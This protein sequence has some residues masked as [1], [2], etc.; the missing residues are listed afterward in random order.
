MICRGTRWWAWKAPKHYHYRLGS[1]STPMPIYHAD[2]VLFNDLG[3]SANHLPLLFLALMFV[4]SPPRSVTNTA[5][6]SSS[7]HRPRHPLCL[8]VRKSHLCCQSL[9]YLGLAQ[10]KSLRGLREDRRVE[11]K[12]MLVIRWA[13]CKFCLLWQ[14]S[15][16]TTLKQMQVPLPALLKGTK[17]C[18]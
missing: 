15:H 4:N 18:L 13:A 7:P 11:G 2:D 6:C 9:A 12:S 3:T 1:A 5:H 8:P 16:K 14:G 10:I 17:G